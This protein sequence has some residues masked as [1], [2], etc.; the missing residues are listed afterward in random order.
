LKP[1]VLVVGFQRSQEESGVLWLAPWPLTG[2]GPLNIRDRLR[3]KATADRVTNIK[4]LQRQKR[5]GAS[6]ETPPPQTYFEAALPA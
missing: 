1:A 5:A 4:I 3:V 6:E 2:V